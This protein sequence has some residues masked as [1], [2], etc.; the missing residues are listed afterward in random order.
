M[1]IASEKSRRTEPPKKNRQMIGI[2]VTVLV[3]RVRLSVWLMLSFMICSIEPRLPAGQTFTDS[4]V[5]DDGVVN[6]ITGDGQDRADHGQRQLPAE[7]REDAD[8]DEHVVQQRDDRADGERELESERDEN[9][10]AENAEARAQQGRLGQLAADQ[11]A[12][13]L[14]ALDLE[15]RLRHT[16]WRSVSRSPRS[17]SPGCGW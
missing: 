1:M 5:N 3:R 6:R 12:D 15:L 8:G 16:P 9:Q 10:D 17:C 14:G 11:R 7:E 4:I 2:N 13:A